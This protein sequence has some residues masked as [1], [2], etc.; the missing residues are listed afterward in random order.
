[1][2]QGLQKALSGR[3]FCA[4]VKCHSKSPLALPWM[5]AGVLLRGMTATP[6]CTFHRS[7]TCQRPGRKLSRYTASANP[8]ASKEYMRFMTKFNNT[9]LATRIPTSATYCRHYNPFPGLTTVLLQDQQP[10]PGYQEQPITQL[11]PLQTLEHHCKVG[12]GLRRQGAVHNTSSP[13]ANTRAWRTYLTARLA[14]GRACAG[15]RPVS[16]ATRSTSGSVS[17]P[18]LPWPRGEYA[19]LR[20]P[21]TQ[22]RKTQHQQGAGHEAMPL[23]HA[24]RLSVSSPCTQHWFVIASQ[25]L[26]KRCCPYRMQLASHP[27]QPFARSHGCALLAEAVGKLLTRCT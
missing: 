13:A 21:C 27:L 22:N 19:T 16:S 15:G 20:S 2:A 12:Q 14:I 8:T 23:P 5:L 3:A 4:S 18:P 26:H 1:M 17:R 9:T 24:A 10:S 7:S 25:G 11:A 6:R